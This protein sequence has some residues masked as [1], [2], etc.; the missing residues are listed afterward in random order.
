MTNTP[1]GDRLSWG[2]ALFLYLEREGMPM[3]IASVSIFEGEISLEACTKSLESRLPSLP[4]YYQRVVAPTWNI[5][6][7]SWEFDPEFDIPNHVREV[8]LKRGTEAELK[9]LAGKLLSKVMDRRRPLWDFTLVHGLKGNCTG[10]LLRIH[11]C[12]ADGIAGIGLMNLLMDPGP[13]GRPLSKQKA[14]RLPRRRRRG[15]SSTRLL[16]NSI[17]TCSDLIQR[18]LTTHSE[19]LNITER[20]AGTGSEL[21][22]QEFNRLLP[23]LTAPPERLFFNVTYQGPQKFAWAKIP[24]PAIKAIREKCGGTHNDVV[25][26][27][28]TAT[29]RRYAELHGDKVKGRLLRMMVPV[30][31]RSNDAAGELG[32]QISI[33]PVNVPLGI[34]SS[35]KLLAAVHRRME[36]LKRSHM[37]ELVALAGGLV[38]FVPAPLQAFFGPFAS[39]LPITPFN[40]VCT[41][42]RGPQAPLYFLG[43][44]ML[45]W[46]PYVP[47]GGEMTVN[48]A[49]LSY[50]DISYFGFSGDSQAAPDLGQLEK[51]LRVSFAELQQASGI[52]PPRK[53]NPAKTKSVVARKFQS[54]VAP[55]VSI[56]TPVIEPEKLQRPAAKEEHRPS[57]MAAD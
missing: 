30:S 41:N 12:L 33:L 46:Y 13:E 36:F 54:H 19:M 16:E 7:P 29:I 4:R 57:P 25:L 2:D 53:T 22:G 51:L 43:H 48:C 49:V 31:V 14:P 45:D 15:D 40:L 27:L 32:N 26:A 35:R 37:A 34:R 24:L 8:T 11:H 10:L 23:E 52:K 1:S 55:T 42:I 3:N 56:A 47:I 5:G 17:T 9:T 18:I 39:V 6:F 44:K 20:I 28:I 38:G 21:P 50:N